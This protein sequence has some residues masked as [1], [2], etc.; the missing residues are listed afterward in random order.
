MESINSLPITMMRVFL[1][2]ILIANL[3]PVSAQVEVEVY[4]VK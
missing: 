1:K 2:I 3:L 4:P